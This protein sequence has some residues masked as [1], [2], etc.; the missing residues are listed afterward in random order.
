MLMI[1]HTTD[2]ELYAWTSS[3]VALSLAMHQVFWFTFHNQALA[4][5][6]EIILFNPSAFF[7]D[8][9]GYEYT[10]MRLA[11]VNAISGIRVISE[12]P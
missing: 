2:I 10:A 7:E 12:H 3:K 11:P 9:T 1:Q 4:K 8:S 6:W 5:C